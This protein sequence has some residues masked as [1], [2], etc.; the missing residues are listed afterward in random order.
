MK[1]PD[2]IPLVCFVQ[3]IL[4]IFIPGFTHQ[5]EG[6]DFTAFD[7]VNAVNNLRSSKGLSPVQTNDILMSVAQDHSDYQA[8]MNLS[9]HAGRTGGIVKDRV[10]A[11]G[12]GN[13][14]KIVAGE[15]VAS[16]TI[17][18]SGML[19]II[20]NEIWADPVHGGAML[21]PKYQ[22]VGVGIAIGGDMVY[23]TLNLAGV[24]DE[25]GTPVVQPS[26]ISPDSAAPQNN[27]PAI[28]PLH[29][30]T[31]L[32]DGNVYHTVGYGQTLQTIAKI[33]QVDI[34]DLVRINNIDPDK[35]YAGQR[36]WIKLVETPTVTVAPT[37][38]P[39]STLTQS[40]VLPSM[41][42]SL[43]SPIIETTPTMPAA[44]AMNVDSREIGILVIFFFFI[45]VLAYF[46]ISGMIQR[47]RSE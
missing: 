14:K 28:L 1:K 15:N 12:Y 34:D 23:V 24:V 20:M 46:V 2:F 38:T 35:I 33:Y 11:A 45:M 36:L 6:A 21:N 3:I 29:T 41:E 18:I 13:G 5:V 9:T 32:A 8:S 43:T 44:S 40:P 17:G 37:D 4:L 42:M 30:C 22:D 25:S 10:A 16:L 26:M 47:N 27:Q 7:M 39:F 31:P 19:D